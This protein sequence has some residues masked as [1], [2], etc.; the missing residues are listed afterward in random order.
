M[1][2]PQTRSRQTKVLPLGREPGRPEWNE[3]G[4]GAGQS[5]MGSSHGTQALRTT[6]RSLSFIPRAIG[7]HCRFS[8]EKRKDLICV[9]DTSFCCGG[10]GEN[11]LQWA[12]G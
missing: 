6:A 9:L 7:R 8:A 11:R 1:Q 12:W 5:G 4:E 10:E 2:C 3:L